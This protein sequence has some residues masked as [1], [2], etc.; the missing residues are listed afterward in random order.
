[1]SYLTV[2][3]P[4]TRGIV[5]R[6]P[7]TRDQ[8]MLLLAA[9]TELF[10]GIDIY[11]AHS[12]S[13]TIKSTE[14]IPI[15]FGVVAG[16]ILL[17]AGLLAFRNRPLAT[18]LAN[19]VFLGSIIV[20]LMGAYFHLVRANLIGGGTPI[21][22]TVSVLI[23]APPFLG[24]L[25]F[26]LNGVLGISA[27]WIEEPVDSG[28]LRLLGNAH[29]QMPYSKTRAYFFIVSIGL[30]ATTISSVLDHARINLENPWVWIPTVAGIFAIVVSASL[31][32]IFRPSRNDLII[33]AVTMA[34]MCL[35][36]VVGFILHV[37]TNLIAN[38]S[39][40]I[41]RFVRGSPFLAP[42]VF[43]NWGLIGLVA[44]LNPVEESRD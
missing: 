24:P 8:A 36:G 2:V 9:I 19:I 39:I 10:L 42:L 12:I 22:E 11:F 14:W 21:S 29:V 34:L 31:G 13:G 27:A 7:I 6:L 16:I 18:V 20:G 4:A 43:A 33:Y 26:A 30:L 17:L 25:F 37:N 41:E 40:L 32:F 3:L 28:R 5:N 1:M 15:V 35:V 44:L 23:W 38:G